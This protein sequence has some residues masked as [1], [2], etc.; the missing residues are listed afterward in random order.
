MKYHHTS[1]RTADIFQ[2]IAFY[3]ALGFEVTERLYSR[4]YAGLLD[5]RRRDSS[6]INASS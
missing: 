5:A 3:E 1:I 4:D 2:S 6:R